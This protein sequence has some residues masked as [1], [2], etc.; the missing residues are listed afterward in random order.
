L[1]GAFNSHIDFAAERPEVDWFGEQRL[2]A[3]LQSV[4]LRLRIAV[5]GDHDDG[6]V[7]SQCLGLGQQFKTAHPR[8]VD[9]G[10]D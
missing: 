9:V 8:H 2:S 7:R 4:A 3:A 5:G 10:E 1:C 6:D